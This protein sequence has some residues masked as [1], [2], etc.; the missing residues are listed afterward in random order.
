M[1]AFILFKYKEY[2]QLTKTDINVPNINMPMIQ[3]NT[4]IYK[5][6]TNSID[7]IV[8]DN[9]RKPVSLTGLLL[10]ARI[11]RVDG[12]QTLLL[13]KQ[14]NIIDEKA[15]KAQL[16]LNDSDI[17]HWDT[18]YYRFTV[19]TIDINQIESYLFT[20]INKNTYGTFQIMDG[21][22]V[23]IDPAK[24]IYS[25]HF[26]ERPYGDYSIM[27]TTS[28]LTGDSQLGQA[29]GLHTV[30]IYTTNFQGKFWIQ[31]SLSI[32]PPLDSEWFTIPI[33]DATEYLEFNETTLR[34]GKQYAKIINFSLNAYWVRFAYWADKISNTGTFD[35]ILYKN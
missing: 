18:G 13:C 7:F 16:I 35:K 10:N 32:E 11:Q 25:K 31:S 23:S 19:S 5:G 21:V 30:A 20:D 1:T 14:I 26:T 24:E 9:D 28:A 22:A 8:R 29:N 12:D 27:W 34:D 6:I 17:Q 3:Y 15:G 2:I 4:K 33:G